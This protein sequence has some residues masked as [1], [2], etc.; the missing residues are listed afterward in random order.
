[1]S[2]DGIIFDMD[3]T[4][5]NSIKGICGTWKEVLSDYPQIKKEV[6][7]EDMVS[8]MGLQIRDIGRKLF[9]EVDEKLST[10]L[11]YECCEREQVYLAKHGGVL[12]PDIEE[13][14]S[15]LSKKYKLFIVSNCYQ[16][17]IDAFFTAHK[18]K[19]YFTDS[20]SAGR[21]GLT[22]GENNKLIIKRNNLKNAVYVG[23][24]RGDREAARVAG[25]PFVFAKYGFGDVKDYDYAID[26]FKD[27]LKL[28]EV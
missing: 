19:K 8:C 28:A 18:L 15:K 21:T 23:D 26:S 10:H 20:E 4:L 22:K 11:M 13:V 12:Y 2:V 27:L 1:M 16:G 25:I 24:T 14:L 9:P 17:Y 5:W 6:T 3:G 7:Y